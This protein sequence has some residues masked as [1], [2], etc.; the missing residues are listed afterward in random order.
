LVWEQVFDILNGNY[1]MR[2]LELKYD[3]DKLLNKLNKREKSVLEKRYYQG[4]TIEEIGNI[5]GLSNER[6]RQIEAKGL[7]FVRK[8][9]VELR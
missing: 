7:R 6:I 2:N 4:M 9:M 8:N 5:Y 3:L 1:F